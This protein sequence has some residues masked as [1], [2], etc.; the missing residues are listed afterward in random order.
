MLRK[1]LVLARHKKFLTQ[2]EVA[3]Y[4]GVKQSR[5]SKI[6]NGKHPTMEQAKL[7]V[8]LLKIKIEIL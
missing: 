3:T 1:E 8:K 5:Y 2:S 6:E 7:L 4:I